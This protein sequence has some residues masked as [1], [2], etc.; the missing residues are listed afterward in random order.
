MRDP[1]LSVQ[2][3]TVRFNTRRG[4]A[5]V[6]NGVSWDVA[7]GET[8]AIV[9]ES[10]S[11]K[12]VSTM[13]MVGLVP[14]PPARIGGSVLFEGRELLGAPAS[15]LR[16]VRGGGIGIVFQDPMTSLNPVMRVGRQIGESLEL[17][18][19]LRGEALRRRSIELLDEVGIPSP[20]KRVD[21][22]PHQFSGGMRQRVMIAIALAGQP[23]VLIA[24]E[25]TT[26]LDVTTQAQIIQLVA[27]LQE[28]L[29]TAVMWITHDLGV[30]AGIADRVLVMYAGE[31]VEEAP[32]EALYE[33]PRH[34]YTVGLLGSLPSVG[35]AGAELATIRGTPP[36]PRNRP[37]GCAF[38]PRCSQR[39]DS[40][41]ATEKPPLRE[42]ATGHW[43][44]AFYE[45][46]ASP[47]EA[48]S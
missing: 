10:G 17:H 31:V 2:D 16:R 43:V 14:Q 13:S 37:P 27:Q 15:E 42:V 4:V 44:R 26:A 46:D 47:L 19:G 41:C 32:V 24:D 6:V 40:R 7:P 8:L 21:D 5:S 20:E 39:L 28:D 22:Y 1:V 35:A 38:Y 11:G 30:V 45:A 23:K 29:G 12:S 25:P 34:P 36:D 3:L 33:T 9:G 48:V 18:L